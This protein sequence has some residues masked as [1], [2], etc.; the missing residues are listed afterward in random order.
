MELGGGTKLI[1]WLFVIAIGIGMLI[2]NSPLFLIALVGTLAW[3]GY[4]LRPN[5]TS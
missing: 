1:G 4:V 3:I 2:E 5:H